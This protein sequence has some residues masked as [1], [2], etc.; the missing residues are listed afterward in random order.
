MKNIDRIRMMGTGQLAKFLTD[1]GAETPLD[2]CQGCEHYLGEEQ[3]CPECEYNDDQKAWK[4]WLNREAPED[5]EE[6]KCLER[7]YTAMMHDMYGIPTKRQ[8][9]AFCT[10]KIFG[11]TL[12]AVEQALGFKLYKWVKDYLITGSDEFRRTGETTARHLRLLL[13]NAPNETHYLAKGKRRF[14]QFEFEMCQLR[15][16]RNRLAAAGIK[17]NKIKVTGWHSSGTEDL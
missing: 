11:T 4:N 1:N 10:E 5:Q 14:T 7:S 16:V 3:D 2:F 13:Y 6:N 15:A 12:A 8:D 17:T 9:E